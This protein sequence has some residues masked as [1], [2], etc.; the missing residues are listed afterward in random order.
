[1]AK[2]ASDKGDSKLEEQNAARLLEEYRANVELWKHDDNLRQQRDTKFLTV[3]T[4]LLVALGVIFQQGSTHFNSW[5]IG[6]AFSVIGC[7]TCS[8]WSIVLARNADYIRFRRFQ[9]RSIES[10]LRPMST[11]EN[12]YRGFS[13]HEPVSFPGIDDKFKITLLGQ[14]NSTWTENILPKVVF[15]FWVLILVVSAYMSLSIRPGS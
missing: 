11:F 7:A 9:L 14:L 13:E 6:L 8:A 3:N 5:I 4:I 1:M 2:D 15:A 12:M 10:Q